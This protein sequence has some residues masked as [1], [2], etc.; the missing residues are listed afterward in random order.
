MVAID[1]IQNHPMIKEVI[2]DIDA[3][4]SYFL[5]RP[6]HYGMSKWSSLQATEKAL[7]AYLRKMEIDFPR[8]HN[9]SIL[10][11]LATENGLFQIPMVTINEIQCAAGV[12]YG[13]IEIN[14][15]EA[16]R[17]HLASIKVCGIIAK[18]IQ[19]QAVE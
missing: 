8:N 10:S 15:Y 14:T 1:E 9:L 6:P 11:R 17:A 3:S 19:S 18:R 13:E 12:R 5:A 2:S 4:V 7:K 16:Y